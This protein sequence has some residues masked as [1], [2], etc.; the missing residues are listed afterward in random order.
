MSLA[1]TIRS[2][3]RPFIFGRKTRSVIV[4]AIT[5]IPINIPDIDLI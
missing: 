2:P 3:I 1:D 5:I 4:R